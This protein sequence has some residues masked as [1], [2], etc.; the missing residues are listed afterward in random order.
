MSLTDAVVFL[1]ELQKPDTSEHVRDSY[2]EQTRQSPE[3]SRSCTD[4]TLDDMAAEEG[5]T[6][7][8]DTSLDPCCCINA[9]Y[10]RADQKIGNLILNHAGKLSMKHVVTRGL[11][12]VSI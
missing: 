5:M 6:R 10:Q 11:T 4:S 2:T 12:D 3:Y 8:P 7:Y 9:D 1:V